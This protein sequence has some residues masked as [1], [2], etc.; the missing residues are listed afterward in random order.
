MI[1]V[2]YPGRVPPYV[3]EMRLQDDAGELVQ[4]ADGWILRDRVLVSQAD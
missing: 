3:A 4:V 1:V 2:V